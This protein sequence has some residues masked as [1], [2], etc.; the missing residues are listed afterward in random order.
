MFF[1]YSKFNEQSGE[2]TSSFPKQKEVAYN[3]KKVNNGW[4]TYIYVIR[5]LRVKRIDQ[6]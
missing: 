5:Q 4:K 6:V 2:H 1:F 3:L